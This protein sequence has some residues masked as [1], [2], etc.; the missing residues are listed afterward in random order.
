[1]ATTAAAPPPAPYS[2]RPIDD[3]PPTRS[4]RPM[5][6]TSL[7]D[8]DPPTPGPS[9]PTAVTRSP[10][11]PAPP[12]GHDLMALF[13]PAA[14][15]PAPS[16]SSSSAASS[17][18]PY[19]YDAPRIPTSGYFARQERAFFAQAGKE[20]VRVRVD[21]DFDV[22]GREGYLRERERESAKRRW[23]SA[24][25]TGGVPL[26]PPAPSAPTTS[27]AAN[28]PYPPPMRAAPPPR[29]HSH[30]RGGSTSTPQLVPASAFPPHPHPHAHHS[31]V[32]HPPHPHSAHP[33]PHPSHA[34]AHS[35]PPPP[36]TRHS[37][38]GT[39][40]MHHEIPPPPPP[41]HPH[42][43]H[44][45]SASMDVDRLSEHDMQVDEPPSRRR[46]SADSERGGDDEERPQTGGL[47][48][49]GNG[50]G[51]GANGNE[52][53]RAGKHTRRVVVEGR[54]GDLKRKGT[55]DECW[56]E[57]ENI[58]PAGGRV[59]A[60]SYLSAMRHSNSNHLPLLM[61]SASTSTSSFPL[62]THPRPRLRHATSPVL[63]LSPVSLPCWAPPPSSLPNPALSVL[64][65]PDPDAAVKIVGNG[66]GFDIEDG[67]PPH[68]MASI[69]QEG[70]KEVSLGLQYCYCYLLRALRIL[71]ADRRLT[72]DTILRPLSA[73]DANTHPI[74]GVFLST[75]ASLRPHALSRASMLRPAL[76][77]SLTR[78]A[79]ELAQR[80]IG[81]RLP[82]ASFVGSGL[83]MITLRL[84]GLR[85]LL[86][87][88][89][90]TTRNETTLEPC[91]T[92]FARDSDTGH[93]LRVLSTPSSSR[94]P[95]LHICRSIT[96]FP[97]PPS[98]IICLPQTVYLVLG[99]V[100]VAFAVYVVLD[101]EDFVSCFR[102]SC[103]AA[104]PSGS[105]RGAE[106]GEGPLV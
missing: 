29:A 95:P 63:S 54:G 34:H 40:R 74:V 6:P 100:S 88:R 53:R 28:S 86:S 19:A 80:A 41:P 24:A 77:D 79:V 81:D 8:L 17:S 43:H 106:R 26:P 47:P 76:M 82:P 50:N 20:I 45:R 14:P 21:V 89:R 69:R 37:M 9:A 56:E 12:T 42:A 32:S 44:H 25:V 73:L 36:H 49:N 46:R 10:H 52:R 94:V 2:L 91:C 33:S 38:E 57:E 61:S 102:G 64:P 92:G 48:M 67:T 22:N 78:R 11:Y 105:S 103:G 83:W 27:S 99:P 23:P 66:S 59:D 72:L 104:L 31:S 7:R 1:M 71:D 3:P 30:T 98:V 70:N 4:R 97:S 15:Y 5:S 93:E 58:R 68:L 35:L 101:D 51:M 75:S 87:I 90:D 62:L 13:P 55:N 85:R 65:Y 84:A 96:P 16:P 18:V 60:T 39:P